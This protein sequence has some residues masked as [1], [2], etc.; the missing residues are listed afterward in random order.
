MFLI[1]F[2]ICG[3]LE[4][5]ASYFMEKDFQ[6]DGGI[7]YKP[8]NLNGRIWIGNLILFGLGGLIVVKPS[9]NYL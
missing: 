9:P 3:I 6:S 5:F 2:I 4:Y 8:M 1:S 7:I